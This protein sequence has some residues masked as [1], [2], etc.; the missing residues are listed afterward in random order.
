MQF[1]VL[2][3][4][5]MSV[6]E[7]FKSA[8]LLSKIH[9][10]L[11]PVIILFHIIGIAIPQWTKYGGFKKGLWKFCISGCASYAYTPSFLE[12][13]QAFGVIATLLLIG[14]LVALVL[15]VFTDLI[16]KKLLTYGLVGCS[17]IAG[18]HFS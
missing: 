12:A 18:K 11:L 2:T 9:L 7:K 4:T 13:C 16:K 6:V 5:R 17:A 15:R 10:I 14:S 3:L 1:S 8:S